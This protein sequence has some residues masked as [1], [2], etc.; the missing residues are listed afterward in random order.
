MSERHRE[1]GKMGGVA[2]RLHVE[3]H[4]A[5]YIAEMLQKLDYGPVSRSTVWRWL[6]R[7]A[8]PLVG[9]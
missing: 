1:W 5:P 7:H 8:L 4:G 3:G 6:R 9:A 2:W